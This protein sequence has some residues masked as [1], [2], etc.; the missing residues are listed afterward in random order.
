MK[1]KKGFTLV[2][3]LAV[4][5]ILAILVIIALPNVMGM[6]NQAKSSSFKVE[7]QSYMDEASKAF[8][9]ESIKAGGKGVCFTGKSTENG[10]TSGVTGTGLT[11]DMSGRSKDYVIYL[12]RKGNVKYVYVRD[13]DYF[14]EYDADYAVSA[15]GT[16][17]ATPVITKVTSDSDLT[18]K[19]IKT[20][21]SLTKADVDVSNIVES[22]EEN[23][24]PHRQCTSTSAVSDANEYT[25]TTE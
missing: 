9:T 3:L 20:N 15:N 13:A 23:Q 14:F 21:S 11:L 1:N 24:A 16:T 2:E 7:V 10:T 25:V 22:L 5:A 19:F 4:I 17:T 6:F 12:D 8:M 18:A